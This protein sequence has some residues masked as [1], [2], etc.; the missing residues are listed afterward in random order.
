M[1]TPIRRLGLV[2]AA[3]F[4]ALLLAST[5]IQ[6]VQA[7]ALNDKPGNR[8]TMLAS[9]AK[10][11]GSII[12]DGRAVADSQPSN[13]DYKWQRRYN[14]GPLYAA[15][16]GYFS[17]IYGTSGVERGYN[18]Y[19]S[20]SSD[21][22]FY[23]RLTD[24][25]TGKTPQG[26]SVDLTI[27][28][29][30]QQVATQALGKQKGAVVALDPKTGAIL[31][32]VTSPSYDPNL[33]AGHDMTKVQNNWNALLKDPDN[34]LVNRT[35]GGNLYP[36]GSTFK[37]VTTAA[38]LQ[39]GKYQPDSELP[40]PATMKLPGTSN[41][42]LP[43]DDNR[44]CGPGDKTSLTRALAVSCNTAYASLGLDL[45][46]NA[47]RDQA[48]KFGFGMD[49]SIPM[50]VTPSTFPSELNQPQL[51]QSA[52]GQ[53]D[54][55]VTPLQVAMMSAGIAN[56][57]KVMRPYLVQTVRDKNLDV[58]STTDPS[59]FS[60]AVSSDVASQLRDMM[61]GVVDNGTGTNARIPGI[62]VAGKTGTAE[63]GKGKIQH[64]W[65][66]GF[67]PANDPKVAVAVIVENGGTAGQEAS[68][69]SVAAP[70]A[71]KVMEAVVSP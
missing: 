47:L 53:Y 34:P 36:P 31:A 43:T 22:L 69:A 2:V 57:G 13:D 15:A 49:L 44:P 68:G 27:K 17:F 58:I 18:A 71:K 37:L 20:G 59:T 48:S 3:M 51:A 32:L 24:I 61:V 19:L 38:A 4:C 42:Y 50:S 11:R 64:V 55:R 14:Q 41:T 67:A 28:A 8:R 29:K 6:F 25:L 65:F 54:V 63:H 62:Q 46:G 12:V 56:G 10:E 5:M 70:I 39:S 26:A 9:Y 52:I 23:R 66:T 30:V 33:L 7:K 21:K 60:Q 45:G 35:I 1:N 16:T 40:G